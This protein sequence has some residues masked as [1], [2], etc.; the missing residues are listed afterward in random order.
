M[1]DVPVVMELLKCSLYQTQRETLLSSINP[2]IS[3]VIPENTS[4]NLAEILLY[5]NEKLDHHQ[6]KIILM[7]TISFIKATGRLS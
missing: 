2:I 1:I 6:N 4:N 7:A 5:G 3:S